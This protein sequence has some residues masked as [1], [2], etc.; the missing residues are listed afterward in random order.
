MKVETWSF[1]RFLKARR[2][3][4]EVTSAGIGRSVC[5]RRRQGRR[6]IQ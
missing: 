6:N 5:D 2:D 4:A 3:D 1:S